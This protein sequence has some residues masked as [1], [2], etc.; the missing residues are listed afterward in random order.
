MRASYDCRGDR[1]RN[2]RRH[3]VVLLLH[4]SRRGTAASDVGCL[5][6][7]CRSSEYEGIACAGC[8]RALLIQYIAVVSFVNSELLDGA[9][10]TY[11]WRK[12][13]F[14]TNWCLY[15]LFD[16]LIHVRKLI[17]ATDRREP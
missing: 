7:E 13:V 11:R 1:I 2:R 5:S 9:S 17:V 16:Q 3:E 4:S 10:T 12:N 6:N 8:K 14:D 15:G